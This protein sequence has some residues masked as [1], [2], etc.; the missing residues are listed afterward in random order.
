MNPRSVLLTILL[1]IGLAACQTTAGGPSP[2]VI[3]RLERAGFK[4]DDPKS[5]NQALGK[6][7]LVTKAV[8][9]CADAACADFGL[10]AFAIDPDPKQITAQDVAEFNA[11]NTRQ[12]SRLW[13]KLN[14]GVEDGTFRNISGSVFKV[15]G[16]YAMRVNAQLSRKALRGAGAGSMQLYVAFTYVSKG[17][18][19]RALVSISTSRA[20]ANRWVDPSLID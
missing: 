2:S 7:D 17:G 18:Q 1:A 4:A 3:S 10:V 6:D 11:L 15:E 19:N 16:G 13:T 8:Y 20:A 5:M 12:K 14:D 9:V